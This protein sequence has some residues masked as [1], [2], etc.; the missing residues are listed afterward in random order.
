M[1]VLRSTPRSRRV[2]GGL[3]AASGWPAGILAALVLAASPAQ[4]AA[5]NLSLQTLYEFRSTPENPNPKNPRAG[6]VQGSDGNF[7]GTTALGG[8]NG[9]RGAVFQIT[10]SGLLM[11]LHSFQ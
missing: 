3:V 10:P 7:Y 6:L 1:N 2:L 5:G 8:T 9:E 4:G 11:L